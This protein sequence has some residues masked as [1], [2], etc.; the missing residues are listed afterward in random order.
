[1]ALNIHVIEKVHGR[2]YAPGEPPIF[3]ED[4]MRRAN[5][6]SE[7]MIPVIPDVITGRDRANVRRVINHIAHLLVDEREQRM[8]LD[9]IS[10]VVQHP[11]QKVRYAVLL[12]G[13]QGDGK[14]FFASLLRQVMGHANVRFLAATQLESSF[15]GWAV[16]QCVTCIEEVRLLNEDRFKILNKMKDIITNMVVDITFKGKDPKT[17]I[18][19]T[20]YMMFTNYQDAAPLEENDRRYLI[21]FSQ[22]Q[23]RDA[24]REFMESRPGYYEKLYAAIEESPGAIRKWLLDHEQSEEFSHFGQAPETTAREMMIENARPQFIRDV[25]EIIQSGKCPTVSNEILCLDDL[26]G[27]L[28]M[29]NHDTPAEKSASS[30]LSKHGFMNL[31]K[32]FYNGKRHTFFSRRPELFRMPKSVAFSSKLIREFLDKLKKPDT[33]TALDDEM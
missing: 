22:W 15:N 3:D 9:W 6:Y 4:G 12:Q 28:M 7:T 1:M 31:G 29:G 13:T 19:T 2:R 30:Q 5:L 18:N 32:H 14:S 24:L 10:W 11:G 23:S 20:N 25:R 33:G 27:A 26:S 16:G 8:L 17:M 21:L